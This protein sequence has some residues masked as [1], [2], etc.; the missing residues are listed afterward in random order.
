MYNKRREYTTRILRLGLAAAFIYAGVKTLWFPGYPV[1]NLIPSW[2]IKFGFSAERLL[3]GHALFQIALGLLFL[4]DFQPKIISVIAIID[5]LI[6][7]V[8][9]NFNFYSIDSGNIAAVG[10]ALALFVIS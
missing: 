6:L 7:I 8:L 9:P 10:A 1:I 5:L 2:I 3:F 4:T